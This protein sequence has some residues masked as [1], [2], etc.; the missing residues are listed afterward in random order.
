GRRRGVATGPWNGRTRDSGVFC[1]DR[2]RS[3][4]AGHPGIGGYGARRQERR[5]GSFKLRESVSMNE[6]RDPVDRLLKAELR[7]TGGDALAPATSECVDAETFAAW[8]DGT[9]PPQ[10]T[11]AIELHLADCARCQALM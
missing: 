5:P 1:V 8:A 2:E 7:A 10:Q 11:G 3:G 4:R 6:P 9:L